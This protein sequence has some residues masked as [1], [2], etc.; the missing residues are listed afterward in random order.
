MTS[1]TTSNVRSQLRK[2]VLLLQSRLS[3]SSLS[4]TGSRSPSSSSV[5]LRPD[6]RQVLSLQVKAA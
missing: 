2:N 5:W 4:M 1:K 3:S 6:R